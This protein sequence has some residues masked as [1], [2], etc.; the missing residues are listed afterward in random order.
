M[1]APAGG[2]CY[3][4]T[5]DPAPPDALLG[6]VHGAVG[7]VY[8]VRLDDGRMVE[9]S[10]RGRVK[11][12]A[13]VGSRVVIGD[14]VEVARSGDAWTIDTVR[15]RVTE[16]AR[17][18]RGGREPKV[19]AANLDRVFAVVALQAPPATC[20]LIDRML[21]LAEASGM[22]PTLILNKLD[23]EGARV[24]AAAFTELYESIGYRVL[25]TSAV[26]GEGLDTLHDEMCTGS[27][28]FIGPS[29]VGKSSLLNALDPTL[30]LE[31]GALSRKTGT[32][33]HTTVDSRLIRMR[34]GG[35][36]ADTPG[37]GDVGLWAVT[38]EEVARCFPEFSPHA[39]TCR[40]RACTHVHEP[41]CRVRAAV[42]H[43][44]IAETRYASYR[45]LRAEAEESES[46]AY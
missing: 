45:K 15:E 11:K 28:A 38:P 14:R 33:R 24:A 8:T 13:R 25:P 44:E 35:L 26:S 6:S 43:G 5:S 4:V 9:A 39:R 10:L 42:A 19:F 1:H 17:R 36:V 34:C 12:T 16:L 7:G 41:G 27:S 21:L 22:H 46:T 32:G 30:Q 31:T 29:G 3:P 2:F 37:F 23:L 40:F 18:G 20:E